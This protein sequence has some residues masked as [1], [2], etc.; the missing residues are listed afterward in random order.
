MTS[1]SSRAQ[2]YTLLVISGYLASACQVHWSTLASQ[3]EDP[4]GME[5]DSR[6]DREDYASPG[7]GMG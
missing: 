5:D 2:V 7:R 4:Y 1:S 3:I 6:A